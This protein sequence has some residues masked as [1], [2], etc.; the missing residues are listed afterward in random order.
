[1]ENRKAQLY[2]ALKALGVKNARVHVENRFDRGEV[3]ANGKYFGVFDYAR[4]TFVD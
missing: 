3:Y 4:N 1:M 2:N